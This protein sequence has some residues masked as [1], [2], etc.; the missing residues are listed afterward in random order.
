MSIE[1]CAIDLETTG[2]NPYRDAICEIGMVRFKYNDE[3]IIKSFS[4]L[5]NPRRAIPAEVTIIHGI[6]D[7]MVENSPY[8]E[9]QMDEILG[10]IGKRPLVIQ[11]PRFDLSFLQLAFKK[12]GKK[13]EP[14]IVYDTVSLA[15]FVFPDLKNHKLET[16]CRYLNYECSFH[17]ALDDAVGCMTVFNRGCSKLFGAKLK[18]DALFDICGFSCREHL[19]H[20]VNI[21]NMMEVQKR[22]HIE[23]KDSNGNVTEREILVQ[24]IFK[25]G[26]KTV[27]HAWCYLRNEERYF[28]FERMKN[29]REA[30]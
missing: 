4:T 23:Y 17:R 27:I 9:T 16:V 11:N 5:I 15:K 19:L 26:K 1:F 28:N 2:V 18:K 12:I 10:F 8:I 25:Q 22:F 14:G 24:G 7:S 13:F 21:F 30:G 29:I 20:R 6:T 3:K